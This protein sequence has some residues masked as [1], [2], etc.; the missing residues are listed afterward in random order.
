MALSVD[1]LYHE[2]ASFMIRDVTYHLELPATIKIHNGFH[3]SKLKRFVGDLNTCFRNL[4]DKFLNQHPLREPKAILKNKEILRQG[5]CFTEVLAQWKVQ[6]TGDA[7]WE[8]AE[9]FHI[10]FA[11]FILK[12]K[13]KTKGELLLQCQLLRRVAWDVSSKPR[14]PGVVQEGIMDKAATNSIIL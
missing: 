1:G 9:D 4:P 13:D 14:C 12:D 2:F 11:A 3:V 6:S 5:Q 10:T 8:D 7:M